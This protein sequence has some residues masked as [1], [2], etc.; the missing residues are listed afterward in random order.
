MIQTAAAA[1]FFLGYILIAAEHKTKT[2][3]SAIALI[4]GTLLWILVPFFDKLH[5]QQDLIE[6]G[7]EIFSIV[8]FLLSAMS[9]VEI[10]VHYRFF[11]LVRGKLFVLNL[12]ER[13]QFLVISFLS[14]FLS[15]IIDNLTCTI[16][17][18]QIATKFFSKENLLKAVTVIVIAA[19]A[20]GA[21][22][23]LGDVTTIMLWLSGKF[24][25]VQIIT[26]GFLPSL[27]MLLF[28]L[29][30]VYPTIK[31]RRDDIKYELV[32][33]LGRSEKLIILLVFGSF[34][35]PI[36][37]SQLHL[38]PYLGLLL[39][40]GVIWITIDTFKQIR[41]KP[42]H[43]EAKIEELIKKTDIPS[44]QFF[45]GILLAVAALNKLNILEGLSFYIYGLNP[46]ELRIIF[47]NIGMGVLSSI[48]DNVPLTAIAIDILHTNNT[49]LWILLTL[50]VGT[51]GS[52]LVIGSAAGV[53]AMGMVKN[54]NF[55]EYFKIAFF[56]V[57]I[58]YSAAISV[59][60]IQY[61]VFRF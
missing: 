10:L 11:D 43:L 50:C 1:V 52:F 41:P 15:A 29:I 45:I 19:N 8:I 56:P 58:G 23:P 5:F 34:T 9:L 13:N 2:N 33:K 26:R 51:G 35:L 21:F 36:V 27:A 38:P 55:V 12:S 22:S 30:L 47:G 25:A 59:W 18:T 53:I 14:F 40:L 6:T 42:T 48:L 49:S 54:L 16:V 39:G 4:M 44:L 28:P 20:G 7:S 3:K 24:D 32:T 57:L 60:A 61:F 37:L 31:Q 46:S 17:M